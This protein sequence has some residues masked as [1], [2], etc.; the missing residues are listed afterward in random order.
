MK[1]IITYL[2]VAAAGAFALA[3]CQKDEA[4]RL[5]LGA[6]TLNFPAD[7]GSATFTI[8]ATK[9]WTITSDNASWYTLSATSGEGDDI[10][11]VSVQ[12]NDD[13]QSRTSTINVSSEDL[14][15]SIEIYQ[16]AKAELNVGSDAL[17]FYMAGGVLTFT[18]NSNYHWTATANGD[19]FTVSQ[20]AG[21]GGETIEVTAEPYTG[22]DSR[23]GSIT[24]NS[25]GLE[26][27]ITV[28]QTWR[29]ANTGEF[30]IEEIFFTGNLLSNGRTSDSSDGD[31]YFRITNNSD[32]TIYADGLFI[33]ISDHDSQA[34]VTGAYEEYPDLKDSIS[35]ATLYKI[36]G[37][38]TTYP[39][40]AGASKVIALTAQNFKAENGVGFDLS[41]ADFEMYD[42][43]EYVEDYDNPDV[44]N[45]ICWFKSSRT[46]STLHN[47]GYQS[48]AIVQIPS[49][50]TTET[51]M[52]DYAWKGQYIFHFSGY[53]FPP[54][55][56]EDAYLIPNDWVI[57]GVNCAV[58]E[59]L[60]KLVFNATIDAGYTNVSTVDS[61]Q[62]R[63]G[64]S[65]VRKKQN[66]KLVDTN[67]ST[68][69]F[70]ISE[71]PSM[72]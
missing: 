24:I 62:N 16:D 66:G 33:A 39:V 51:Y 7:G 52:R 35:I 17:N 31:Q 72:K 53:N 61:D 1:R 14:S 34:T 44:P 9:S 50:I 70:E 32:H 49:S 12:A 43:N 57:D 18:V 10:I 36:P 28:N 2:I 13:T 25:E 47:R 11:T 29:I 48:Y 27:T 64:K 56:I 69:D 63:Y 5:G 54:F 59:N 68:N 55:D 4:A 15:H 26:T 42:D 37:E 46:I 23:T 41:K 65:V 8:D 30:L 67:N 21:N 19:W 58:T 71:N 40:E 60:Y 6:G 3:S 22:N 45:M 20:L 38:G